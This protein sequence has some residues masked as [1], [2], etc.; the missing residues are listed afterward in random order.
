MICEH[1]MT[2]ELM[3]AQRPA[4]IRYEPDPD[5]GFPC[6]Q[7]VEMGRTIRHSGYSEHVSVDVLPIL[8]EADL[9]R[10]EAEI[11]EARPIWRDAA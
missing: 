4:L 2:L 11:V 5:D 1:E 7:A 6:I 9:L 3:G 10:L 8:D